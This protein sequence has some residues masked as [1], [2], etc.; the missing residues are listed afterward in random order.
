MDY[1]LPSF[2]TINCFAPTQTNTSNATP[3]AEYN[4]YFAQVN[5]KIKQNSVSGLVFYAQC[6]HRSLTRPPVLYLPRNAPQPLF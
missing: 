1:I 4:S 3:S 2:P 6:A 5:N